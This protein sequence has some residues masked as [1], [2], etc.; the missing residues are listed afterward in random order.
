MYTQVYIDL[1]IY[2]YAYA[3]TCKYMHA[4]AYLRFPKGAKVF[5]L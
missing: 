1:R 5:K 4:I 3:Y 2:V